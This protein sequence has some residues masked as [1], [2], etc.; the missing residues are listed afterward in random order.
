MAERPDAFE[1]GQDG[2]APFVNPFAEI[3]VTSNS[4][5]HWQQGEA[6]IFVTWRLA[7]SLPTDKLRAWQEE[8]DAW[9]A[10]HPEPWDLATARE[11]H[12]RFT[13]RIEDWLDAGHGACILRNPAVRRIVTDAL[14]FFDGKRYELG[15]WVVM[16]NHVHVLFRPFGEHRLPDILHSW[17]SFSA[18]AIN[19]VLGHTGSVWQE[20]DWDRLI[21]NERH[22]DAVNR[23]ISENPTKAG[24][25]QREWS[26]RFS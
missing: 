22:L 16:P 19:K 15:D 4:L 10:K 3:Q 17:K 1:P 7:D 9:R 5:P 23:Y 26:G 6:W 14:A 18:K 12:E 2:P 21:R 8:K 25:S 24:L 20:D 13:Q 11:Y